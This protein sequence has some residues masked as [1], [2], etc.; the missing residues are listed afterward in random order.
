MKKSK[1]RHTTAA[2][3]A[4]EQKT[5]ARSITLN[6]QTTQRQAK[7]EAKLDSTSEIWKN[8]NGKRP[9]VIISP[10]ISNMT[11]RKHAY[12]SKV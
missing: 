8:F 10:T 11:K 12:K 5:L 2:A 7:N 9:A 6:V 4:E 1:P 3:K